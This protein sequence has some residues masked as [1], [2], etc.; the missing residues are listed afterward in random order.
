[1]L[2]NVVSCYQMEMY[3]KVFAHL[4]LFLSISVFIFCIFSVLVNYKNYNYNNYLLHKPFL[5][6]YLINVIHL[7]VT[8]N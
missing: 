6:M 5:N 8:L 3:C 1:M 2:T 4:F 7:F